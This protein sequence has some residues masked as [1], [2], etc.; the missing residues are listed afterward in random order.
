MSILIFRRWTALARQ[1]GGPQGPRPG[2]TIVRPAKTKLCS[3]GQA[4]I[5]EDIHALRKVRAET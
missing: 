2:A 1:G 5:P 4:V 3:P